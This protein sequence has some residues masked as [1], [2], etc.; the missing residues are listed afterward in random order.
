MNVNFIINKLSR[1]YIHACG[2]L[3]AGRQ[4]DDKETMD[5]CN[6]MILPEVQSSTI[7]FKW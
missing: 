2:L 6:V 3:I 1:G 4:C 5:T 7:D